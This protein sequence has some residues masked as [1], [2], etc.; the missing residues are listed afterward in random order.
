LL[1]IV[2]ELTLQAFYTQAQHLMGLFAEDTTVARAGT[3]ARGR[4][5]DGLLLAEL[6]AISVIRSRQSRRRVTL[7]QYTR[8]MKASDL[9]GFIN[10]IQTLELKPLAKYFARNVER[11]EDLRFAHLNLVYPVIYEGLQNRIRTEVIKDRVIEKI[12]VDHQ[13]TPEFLKEVKR[14]VDEL[15][16]PSAEQYLDQGADSYLKEMCERNPSFATWLRALE[17]SSAMA[18]WS[19]FESLAADV[20]TFAVNSRPDLFAIE[21]LRA[22]NES[23]PEGVSS[24]SI[25]IGV[26]AR[27]NFDLRNCIGDIV[28]R[29]IDFTSLSDIKKAYTAAFNID[30]ETRSLLDSN[31][32]KQ[33]VLVRNL[34]AHRSGVVDVQ[35]KEKTK[36]DVEVGTELQIDID[37]AT[38]L[39]K[40]VTAA[41]ILLVT[42]VDTCLNPP[43]ISTRPIDTIEK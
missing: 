10:T 4:S 35:F 34:I 7:K 8:T 15:K 13:F 31:E 23:L 1:G 18:A 19:A 12:I 32:L 5:G 28:A 29:G 11:A 36:W 38:K 37:L 22:F 20:W 39:I 26:A 2:T 24:R 25:A 21:M 40:T 33:L 9:D 14:R 41:G 27:H 42:A 30:E 6:D 43:S 17:Q 3:H 16:D